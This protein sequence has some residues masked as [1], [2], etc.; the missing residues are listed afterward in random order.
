MTCKNKT[1]ERYIYIYIYVRKNEETRQE[2]GMALHLHNEMVMKKICEGGNKSGLYDHWRML[3]RN[4]RE[5]N[6]SVRM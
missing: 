4:G 6:D 1:H 3:I 5:E 2:T